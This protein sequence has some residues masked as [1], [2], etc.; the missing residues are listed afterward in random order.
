MGV[1][2]DVL[3]SM[4]M[5]LSCCCLLAVVLCGYTASW[6]YVVPYLLL[7]DSPFL[8][9]S[10]AVA[11]AFVVGRDWFVPSLC[12][13][14]VPAS[15]SLLDPCASVSAR[16]F[17]ALCCFLQSPGLQPNIGWPGCACVCYICCCS[18]C[19]VCCFCLFSL[20]LSLS[21][22]GCASAGNLWPLGEGTY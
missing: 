5:S 12:G 4:S 17:V 6:G 3:L 19:V 14:V 15:V 18:Y 21:A 16:A 22:L 10:G 8:Q 7:L 9:R 11:R 1:I 20:F 13:V 2:V